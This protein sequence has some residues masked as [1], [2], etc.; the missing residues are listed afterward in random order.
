MWGAD[1]CIDTLFNSM[2]LDDFI[3]ANHLLRPVHSWRYEAVM[4]DKLFRQVHGRH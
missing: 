4:G 3:P 1:S 2:K